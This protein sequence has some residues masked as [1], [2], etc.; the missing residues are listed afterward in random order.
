M[1]ARPTPTTESSRC[2]HVRACAGACCVSAYIHTRALVTR[3]ALAQAL[4]EEM[5]LHLKKVRQGLTTSR[6]AGAATR[7]QPETRAPYAQPRVAPQLQDMKQNEDPRL[8]FCT[9][10]FKEAQRAFTDAFKVRLRV[11]DQG[12]AAARL[13][14][15]RTA[16]MLCPACVTRSATSGGRWS[17]RSSR[18][19]PGQPHSSGAWTSRS[20]S[21]A[22][23]DARAVA[24]QP[25][26][27]ERGVEHK[28]QLTA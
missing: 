22:D 20:S 8:S 16:R 21:R 27:C 12:A 4:L 9:P 5:R 3:C 24:A 1:S 23:G 15:P 7:P 19:T 26:E 10:D 28:Q 14:H 6:A 2:V 18:S 17:G 25:C 13:C 11:Y